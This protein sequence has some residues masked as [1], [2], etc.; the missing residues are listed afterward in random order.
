MFNNKTG[1]P[2][3]VV[4]IEHININGQQVEAG[5]VIRDCDADLAMDMA[6][7]GRVR[8]AT[9]ADLAK[10]AKAKAKVKLDPVKPEG[11]DQTTAPIA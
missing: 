4:A 2:V 1:K 5:T 8:L 11:G 6:S 9:A 3:D 10:A 7:S